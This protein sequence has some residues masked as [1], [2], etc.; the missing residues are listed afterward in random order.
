LELG[1]HTYE[2]LQY[3]KSEDLDVLSLPPVLARKMLE[4]IEVI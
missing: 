1:V 2:D 3:L 4:L